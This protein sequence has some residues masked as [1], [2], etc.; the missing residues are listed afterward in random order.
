MVSK[1]LARRLALVIADLIS[2]VQTAFLPSRQILDGP[3]IIDELLSW[4]KRKRYQAMLFKVDFAKAY[5][6]IRWEYLD[7]VLAA[8]GFGVKWRF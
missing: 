2:D 5:D 6:S 3:F 1:V 7:D 8:C 4:C